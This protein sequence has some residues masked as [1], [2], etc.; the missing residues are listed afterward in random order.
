MS[1]EPDLE[2]RYRAVPA[3]VVALFG[4]A[5]AVGL[6]LY[7]L[8]PGSAA[9]AVVLTGGL[10]LLMA[11]PAVR[12]LLVFAERMRRRDWLFVVMTAV[13]LLELAIVFGRA[14]AQ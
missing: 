13:V 3:G 1:H 11:A 2:V 7:L 10:I 8:D 6:V 5:F 12:L 9:A 4:I 14:A